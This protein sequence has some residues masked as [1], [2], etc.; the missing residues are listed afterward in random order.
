MAKTIDELVADNGGRPIHH[1]S[2]RGMGRKAPT[3]DAYAVPDGIHW[4]VYCPACQLWHWHGAAP[5]H[6]V[7][8]CGDGKKFLGPKRGMVQ[9]PVMEDGYFLRYAG[10]LTQEIR[11]RHNTEWPAKW[12]SRHARKPPVFKV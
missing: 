12:I 7:Q 6:R 9:F 1:L 8:H 10:K 2:K 4:V 11:D 5:G 3:L